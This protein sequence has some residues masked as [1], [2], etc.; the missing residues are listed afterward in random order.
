M[1]SSQNKFMFFIFI[2]FLSVKSDSEEDKYYFQLYPSENKEK[3]Y[4]FHAY[5]P[6]S[7]FLTINTTD[8]ENCK[9]IEDKNVNE[10][11]IKGLSSVNSLNHQL[12][13]KTCFGPDKIVE[14]INENNQVFSHKSNNVQNLANI[15]FCYSTLIYDPNNSNNFVIITY[16]TEFEIR[17]NKE[18]YIHKCILFY[19][20]EKRFSN[21]IT[22]NENSNFI[23][24]F[25]NKNYYPKNCVTFRN[26]DIYC[27]IN[28]DSS[29]STSY[30][31][32]FV[33]ETKRIFNSENV[34]LV[35]SDTKF[36]KEIFQKPISINYG[37][38]DTLGGY[39]DVFLT[40][41]H[42]KTNNRTK[43]I[44]S[45]YREKSHNSFIFK[46]D[47]MKS[48]YGINI[49]D[50]YIES[51]LFN[52]IFPNS[53]DL[54]IIYTLKTG[55]K[56][57]LLM[58]R[59]NLTNSNKI[60]HDFSKYS[61][62]NYIRDDICLQPKYIQSIF[63]N[64]YIKY[65]EKDS[66]YIKNN[67]GKEKFYKYQKDIITLI[68]CL[69]SGN[70][71]EYQPKKIIMPQCL[72]TLD[73]INSK[74]NHIIK[75]SKDKNYIIFDI[76]NDPNYASLRD[77]EI[78]FISQNKNN[79]PIILN[80]KKSENSIF[81]PFDYNKSIYG[82]THIKFIKTNN[83]KS[84][85]PITIQYRLKQSISTGASAKCHLSS[86]ICEL[87]F[88]IDDNNDNSQCNVPYCKY[89][90][91]NICKECDPQIDGI[92]LNEE[93][94]KCMCDIENGFKAEPDMSIK[95]CI[96]KDNYS[97]FQNTKL[98]LPNIIFKWPYCSNKKDD[99]SSIPIYEY[100]LPNCTLNNS[101]TEPIQPQP[102]IP[103][104]KCLEPDN[105][106]ENIW[107]KLGENK[108]YYA[109]I[110]DCVYIFDK[111]LSLFFHSNNK[112]CS[113]EEDMMDYISFCLNKPEIKSK[114]EYDK[115]LNNSLEYEP[116]S[117]EIKIN[118]KIDN[119]Q[120]NLVNGQTKDDI[121]DV[122]LPED[123]IKELKK[124]YDIDEDLN[125]L[126]FK[127]DI[128]RADTISTQVE[129]QFYNPT[130]NKLYKKINFQKLNN[131]LRRLDDNNSLKVKL[132]LP[133]HWKEYQLN[134]VKELYA[135]KIFLFNSSHDFYLD[136]CFKFTTSNGSDIYLN[137][138]RKK[139]FINEPFCEEGCELIDTHN[140][141]NF[142]KL[143][144]ECPIKYTQEN[145]TNIS[146]V[147][148]E[149]DERFKKS[150]IFPNIRVIKCAKEVFSKEIGKNPSF[151]LF[152]LLFLIFIFSYI[153]RSK[154]YRSFYNTEFDKLRSTIDGYPPNDKGN[155]H[156]NESFEEEREHLYDKKKEEKERQEENERIKAYQ[157]SDD[158]SEGKEINIAYNNNNIN[159]SENKSG[160]TELNPIEIQ[161]LKNN[162]EISCLNGGE[163]VNKEDDIK[164]E[165]KSNI[166]E[167][168][169][170]NIQKENEEKENISNNNQD[171]SK[172][173]ES[174]KNT[175][176]ENDNNPIIDPEFSNL[177]NDEENNDSEENQNHLFVTNSNLKQSMDKDY[178]LKDK[179]NEDSKDK[180][181]EEQEDLEEENIYEDEKS[182]NMRDNNEKKDIKKN[183]FI[184]KDEKKKIKKKKKEKEKE[185]R[186]QNSNKKR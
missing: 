11:V 140:Y 105:L 3:S 110:N 93:L 134:I 114:N 97:F 101:C 1:M 106:E 167:N 20:N 129:Y 145:Y 165:F 179:E 103:T 184:D 115:F 65:N 78:Q 31:N 116:Y 5:I 88:L 182:D 122:I 72:N 48:F 123:T 170:E 113:F 6:P 166:N 52:H 15:K 163:E 50:A 109:Y 130:P 148:Q 45:Y 91:N 35:I 117:P 107:F 55:S 83:F 77:V 12:L 96:C 17:N 26:T 144:C 53:N 87:E 13:I 44:S 137:D 28:F 57:S 41:Y 164:A 16:W 54:L 154:C 21:V 125:L 47:T 69:K 151:Y 79:I 61:I 100:C 42:D 168:N 162:D 153:F 58:S 74:E 90:E 29:D 112:N 173:I 68:T 138:R 95:M 30:G 175:E 60:N 92:M 14:I 150:Y 171:E 132:S 56:M 89:C 8:D 146:F 159:N 32:S 111:D 19:I 10:K 143:V 177:V 120:F 33:I 186:K 25:I 4:L 174:S 118:K 119:I 23:T 139:Y 84:N 141:D 24:Y 185:K 63:S 62:T 142:N 155:L 152:F 22:L 43:L 178:D 99:L 64:S 37:I 98:C 126:I 46:V 75:F 59:F 147:L 180:H 27:S 127:A 82:I 81:L 135:M 38:H 2:L 149:E 181:Q 160:K 128:T 121:S 67:G 49:E 131:T 169:I 133:I 108:F 85:I 104:G 94:N 102:T 157:N 36:D 39:F 66:K 7:R 76:Y 71:V 80:Y 158:D 34:Y 9:I 70:E 73:E 176:G 161:V 40:E 18:I 51:N 86:D 183:T 172:K 124:I 156:V 136:V